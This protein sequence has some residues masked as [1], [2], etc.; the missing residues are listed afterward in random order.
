MRQKLLLSLR[1]SPILFP[2]YPKE[3]VR[4]NLGKSSAVETPM[5]AV[6]AASSLSVRRISGRAP[7]KIGRKTGREVFRD[8]GKAL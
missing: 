4:E 6:A 7:E 3:P 2:W 1:R 5:R 8:F